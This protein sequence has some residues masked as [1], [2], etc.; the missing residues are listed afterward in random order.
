[1]AAADRQ[2]IYQTIQT[3]LAHI[4]S[5]IGQEPLDDYCNRIETA[6]SYTD[7]MITDANTAN[8]NTF[9]DAHKADI[10]KSKMAGKTVD[11]HQSAIQRLSQETFKTDDNPET[12][13][14]RIRQY[15][16][17]VP[18]DD[19][20]ALGFLMAHLPNELFIRM[21]GTNPGSITAFFTTLKEL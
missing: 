14:A 1:M 12:Y 16:L 19:A 21:E 5:Y 15:I 17:G 10:Y 11:T 13:E 3:S 6:I 9:T 20:N 8:A 4:P 2:H 7:T 18:D